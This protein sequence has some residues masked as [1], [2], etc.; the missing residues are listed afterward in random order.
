MT[1]E[2]HKRLTH[3]PVDLTNIHSV[4]EGDKDMERE[5]FN[6]FFESFDRLFGVLETS[7]EEK[8]NAVWRS[9]AHALKGISLNVGGMELARLCKDAQ[10][11]YLLPTADKTSLLASIKVEYAEVHAFLQSCM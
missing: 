7:R 6:Q 9:N 4:T 3:P 8:D 5:L 10:E 11:G 1:A 2:S